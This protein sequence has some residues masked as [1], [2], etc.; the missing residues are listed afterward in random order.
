MKEPGFICLL[1]T[2]LNPHLPSCSS[3]GKTRGGPSARWRLMGSETGYSE[4]VAYSGKAAWL[5]GPQHLPRVSALTCPGD[6]QVPPSRLPWARQGSG[7]LTRWPFRKGLTPV[8]GDKD[9]QKPRLRCGRKE[10]TYTIGI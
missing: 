7:A 1:I 4:S 6:T 9:G 3:S 5:L 8:P 2:S 10:E